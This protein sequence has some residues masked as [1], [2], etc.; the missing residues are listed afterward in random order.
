M[1]DDEIPVKRDDASNPRMGLSTEHPRVEQGALQDP[2]L[3][4]S[5]SQSAAENAPSSDVALNS[6]GVGML[7]FVRMCYWYV[8][9]E[10]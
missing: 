5:P 3:P 1:G 10:S 4:I 7:P 6:Q 9:K 8:A 2:P